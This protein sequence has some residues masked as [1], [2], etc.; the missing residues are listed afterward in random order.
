MSNT[1]LSAQW[2]Y[3]FM[4]NYAVDAAILQPYLPPHTELD[5]W[6]GRC[7]V[8]LVGFLFLNTRVLGIGFPFH[9]NFEEINLRFYVRYRD[10]EHWKRGVVFIREI[11]P[12]PIIAW[13]ANTLYKENYIAIPTRHRHDNQLETR[14]FEYS[15]KWKG[16]WN[17]VKALTAAQEQA[18]PAGSEAEF[19]TEHYWGYARYGSAQT[20]EYEVVHP[21]WN[22]LPLLDY[23]IDCNFGQLY[24]EDFALL[25]GKAPDSVFVAVGSA[26]EVLKGRRI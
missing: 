9:R 10:G 21:R 19:I 22:I 15:W 1:F 23:S 2:R 3:L 12:K 18:I 11:V 13:I 8:S 5:L 16:R 4:A 17:S 7:Y 26:I 25:N 6:E 20:V 14:S 24:G